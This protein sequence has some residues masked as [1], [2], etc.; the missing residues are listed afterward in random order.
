MAFTYENSKKHSRVIKILILFSYLVLSRVIN[1]NAASGN[2]SRVQTFDLM[3]FIIFLIIIV[4]PFFLI[5]FISLYMNHRNNKR[6]QLYYSQQFSNYNQPNI[7]NQSPPLQPQTSYNRPLQQFN[8]GGQFYYPSTI[9]SHRNFLQ[10]NIIACSRCS[11]INF[12]PLTNCYACGDVL[13]N[14]AHPSQMSFF[15]RRNPFFF[16]LILTIILETFF[17]LI[18]MNLY[19]LT[20]NSPSLPYDQGLNVLIKSSPAYQTWFNF[21]SPIAIFIVI[22]EAI[23]LSLL[24]LFMI[25]KKLR[26]PNQFTLK[27]F[28]N[29]KRF[30]IFSPMLN[31]FYTIL[32]TALL[33]Q[34]VR[35]GTYDFLITLMV[36]GIMIGFFAYP[37]RAIINS[38]QFI[39]STDAYWVFSNSRMNENLS[40]N[41]NPTSNSINDQAISKEQ[42]QTV[43]L[44]FQCPIC[45]NLI[46]RSNTYCPHCGA[47]IEFCSLC[48]HPIESLLQRTACPHCQKVFHIS[49]LRESVKITGYC[50]NCKEPLKDDQI[51]VI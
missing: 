38:K 7:P 9:Y 49:H 23:I 6:R 3:S 22:N 46:T 41:S 33:T 28:N 48:N 42:L 27:K 30:Y 31:I 47:R 44:E 51:S 26:Q 12:Q 50:P 14:T 11:A 35:Q 2:N 24:P 1:V 32:F 10:E 36:Y 34:G 45:Y 19:A 21:M 37:F 5:L 39:I 40:P 15:T 16:S 20:G 43:S 29:Y 4:I 13:P 17:A 18:I 8:Q 25:R